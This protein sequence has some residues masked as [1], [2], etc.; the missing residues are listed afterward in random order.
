M[1]TI[2]EKEQIRQLGLLDANEAKLARLFAGLPTFDSVIQNL[3]V[4]TLK[5]RIPAR[6]FRGSLFQ[7]INP[8]GW[9]VNHFTTDEKGVRSLTASQRFIDVSWESLSRDAAPSFPVGGV[10]FFTKAQTVEEADSLFASPVDAGILRA[11]A[12]VFY[13][14]RPTHDASLKR[15][16]RNDLL[17]F[18]NDTNHGERLVPLADDATVL[19]TQAVFAGL[20]A[21]RFLCLW[22]LYKVD[23][24]PVTQLTPR[25]RLLRYDE[26]LMLDRIVTHPSL[27]DRSRLLRAPIPQV[28]ALTLEMGSAPAQNWPA[29]M[30]IKRADHPAVYLYSMEGGLQRFGSA[31]ALI[32][33]VRPIHQ[34]QQRAIQSISSELSGHVFELAAQALLQ[35]QD[36][37][38]EKALEVA[39]SAPLTLQAFAQDTEAALSLPQLSL[40]GP[41]AVRRQTLIENN[42]PDFYQRATVAQ[43][44]HYRRLEE[45]VVRAVEKLGNGIPTLMAFAREK[46]KQYLQQTVH[47]A[48]APDP[49]K[50]RVTLTFGNGGNPRQSRTTNLTQLVL[51]N[52]RAEQ[53]PNAMRQV[54]AV[55][56]IDSTDQRIRNPSNGYLITLT[57]AELATMVITIDAGGRYETML[58]EEMNTPGYK[59]AWQTAYLANMRL[60]GYEATLRDAEVFKTSVIDP[61]IDPS[62]SQKLLALWLD[63]ILKQSPPANRQ[64]R[65]LGRSVR[66]YGLALGGTE[67][68]GGAQRW[69]H[70]VNGALVFTD[71][72]GPAIQGT[73]GVYF[74]D[75]PAGQDYHEFSNLSDGV[76]GL[77]RDAQW[78]AY[79]L[80]RLSTAHPEDIRRIFEQAARP[81]IRGTPITDDFIEVLYREYVAFH[82]AH[83]DH[84]SNS[85][86]DVQRQTALRLSML[87]VDIALEV[88]G[89]LMTPGLVTFLKSVARTGLLVL[90]TGALPLNL[91]SLMFVHKVANYPG[92]ELAGAAATRGHASFLA[93]EARRRGLGETLTG[94]PLEEAVYRR[95]AVT[96][97]SVIRGV[98][99]DGQGFYRTTVIHPTTGSVTRPVYIRQ[100][101]GT[102]YRV[103]DN[104]KL[105]ATEAPLVD[106]ATG[107]NIRSSGVMRSTVA[108][109]P[110]GE[111]R[112]VGFGL[113]GG[114]RPAGAPAPADAPK[115]K[116]P[117]LSSSSVADSIRTPGSWDTDVMDLVPTLVTRLPSWPQNRSLLI[118]DETA[119]ARGWSVRFTPGQPERIYPIVQHPQRSYSDLVLRRTSHNHYSLLLGEQAVQIPADGDCF[120]N[121]VA[122]GLNAAS[123]PNNFS[124]QRLRNEV[125]DYIQQHPETGQY[126]TPEASLQ[127]QALFENAP[128]L[129]QILDESAM[130][131]LTNIMYGA[132]NPHRLFQPALDYLDL[133]GH[134]MQRRVLDQAQ[135]AALPPEILQEIGH[136][137]APASPAN[138]MPERVPYRSLDKQ[139]ISK[140]FEQVLL[141]PV[142]EQHIDQLLNNKYLLITQDV[143]HIMLEY[144]VTARELTDNHPNVDEAFV[145]FDVDTHGHLDED[146]L[147]DLLGDAYLVDRENLDDIA[148][149][150]EDESGRTVTDEAELFQQF[151]YGENVDD[152]V[153]LLR[154]ALVRF[155]VLQQRLE[156]LLTCPVISA[157]LGGLL[158]VSLIAQW[159]RN[160]AISIE[161]LR[162]IVEY[163]RTRINEVM[164][165]ETIDIEWM[166][167]FDDRNLQA[168]LNQRQPLLDFM[169]FLKTVFKSEA[170]IDLPAVVGYFSALGHV[171]SNSRVALLLD[172]PGLLDAIQRLPR[173]Y[174]RRIWE[175][176]V[177]P[178]YSDD[179]LQRVFQRPGALDSLENLS[180]AMS[181]S[182]GREEAHANEIV[183]RLYNV[184]P[185]QAQRYLYQF[186]FPVDRPGH[187]RLDF[188]LYLQSHLQV[189]AWA[190]AYLRPGVSR[191][192][193]ESFNWSS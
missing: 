107:L 130:L 128:S 172:T 177:G 168:I 163:T 106:P 69:A 3:L 61:N 157:H 96:D 193:M 178:Y 82:S 4:S 117:A 179:T 64:G 151:I 17:G 182:L 49:D 92:R 104:T 119:P 80:A 53:Y 43:Q 71:Q 162:L 84:R 27:A 23:R 10:G 65:V 22:H 55:Y 79:F 35:A 20:L 140:F 42:R 180:R 123:T 21:R 51:D 94:L 134:R 158:N 184:F 181:A 19:N 90:K 169:T 191:E 159:L 156:I 73:V 155:P 164:A 170:D 59:T 44:A 131:D 189:P 38:L 91:K 37:A 97:A 125:A 2:Q 188:A 30:V 110:D 136:Y 166:H 152:T 9:Y 78:K 150:L 132:D 100:P 175:D 24:A 41:L 66:L 83:A 5:A 124:V 12:S 113:G 93:L 70:T 34:G 137:L 142:N 141:K 68:I 50:T 153:D 87:A 127:Q 102:V 85:N 28:F 139:A 11:M 63:V 89:M 147:D 165:M 108:R 143:S 36:D 57:G 6:K 138:L 72:D 33:S 146:Q 62:R 111:W 77:L 190:W 114:K 48:I 135:E 186:N 120:F 103:H 122:Q 101:E 129:A 45:R 54:S 56:L 76:A 112:A 171:P 18:R 176:L 109:M 160:P 192:S 183:R 8:E 145:L 187:T 14:S 115:P 81:L 144:G 25:A 7:A 74:P 148:Q 15:Q 118:I 86:R 95:Y 32:D 161:R 60:K 185:S 58:R 1:S 105:N 16:F 121:A 88:S 174:V 52:L 133:Y 116:V 98:T 26:D 99:P 154:A 149:R 31:L 40:T 75:S 167:F 46:I 29:A 173:S 47:P 126:L 39:E 67:G 13:I